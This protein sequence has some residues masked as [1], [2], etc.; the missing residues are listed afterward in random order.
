MEANKRRRRAQGER[1]A[2]VDRAFSVVSS[3]WL[4]ALGAGAL[5]ALHWAEA[6]RALGVGEV[7]S[8]GLPRAM[9]VGLIAASLL[10]AAAARLWPVLG[11]HRAATLE[12]AGVDVDLDV[13]ALD[14]E[15]MGLERRGEGRFVGKLPAVGA[16]LL[17]LALVGFG[18]W[19]LAQVSGLPSGGEL[20]LDPGSFTEAAWV[21]REGLKVQENLAGWR[22]EIDRMEPGRLTGQSQD[23]GKVFLRVTRIQ[24]G[25]TTE[26]TL[27]EGQPV[28]VGEHDLTLTRVAPALRPAGVWVTVTD[29]QEK[30]DFD[31]KLTPGR[32]APDPKGPG[33][34][35]LQSIE[36]NYL[37]SNGAAARGV[38]QVEG[39][40]PSTFWLFE[41]SPDFDPLHRKGRYALKFKELV[42]GHQVVCSISQPQPLDLLPPLMALLPVGLALLLWQTHRSLARGGADEPDRLHAS[43]LND[44][45]ALARWV[46]DRAFVEDEEEGAPT[47]QEN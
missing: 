7:W 20:R 38:V 11:A 43:S 42:P 4:A 17:G 1:L 26:A 2:W 21:Q 15:D 5:A 41:D 16:L 33:R 44:A 12:S 30:R 35:Q 9:G 29:A 39:E 6:H 45:E 24:T 36:E 40:Q 27:T 19:P 37:G 3:P 23:P 13:R 8:A 31:L 28:R 47:A 32:T 14:A 18:A 34:F 22:F 10:A 46:A 25:E